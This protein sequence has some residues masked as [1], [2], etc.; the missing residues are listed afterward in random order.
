MATNQKK[1]TTNKKTAPAKK[2][3]AAAKPAAKALPEAKPKKPSVVAP[4]VLGLL[5]A[6]IILTFF[7]EDR[8][9]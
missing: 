7:I 8:C 2:K 9:V 6:L 4:W 1:S 5:A 3:T